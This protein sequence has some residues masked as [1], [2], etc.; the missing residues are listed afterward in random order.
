MKTASYQA[1][2]HEDINTSLITSINR[3]Q[4]GEVDEPLAMERVVRG[5]NMDDLKAERDARIAAQQKS[6][7][8]DE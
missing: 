8:K 4:D 3:Y 5:L 2:T 6:D 1:L 7:E